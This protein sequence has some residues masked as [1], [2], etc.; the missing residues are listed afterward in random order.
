[1]ALLPNDLN[2]TNCPGLVVKHQLAIAGMDADGFAL[3]YIA[4]KDHF[5][6]LI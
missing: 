4:C 1:M 3:V 2:K 5:R 6:K